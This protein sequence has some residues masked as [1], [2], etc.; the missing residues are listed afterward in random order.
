M[1]EHE[2]KSLLIL[3]DKYRTTRETLDQIKA[4]I[5]E[6]IPDKKIEHQ[7][8]VELESLGH[9]LRNEKVLLNNT[10]GDNDVLKTEID[11][12]RRE[13]NFAKASIK[14]M[15]ETIDKLKGDATDSNREACIFGRQASEIKNQI[16]ALKANHEE[17]KE[18]FEL[19]I[20]KLQEQ[21]KE[22]D[23]KVEFNDKS[24]SQTMQDKKGKGAKQEF[25]NPTEIL[26]IRLNS[27]TQKNV[28][29]KRLLDQFVRNAK[30]IEEAFSTIMEATGINNIEEIVTAFIKAEEQNVQLFNYVGQLGQENDVLEESNRFYDQQIAAFAEAE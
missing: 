3:E 19:D 5:K 1:L 4:K 13:I 11:S 9:Q 27:V 2:R 6:K 26:K 20:K 17:G 22:K 18:E 16:L 14:T 10:I 24:L 15:E 12:M 7:A 29:K 28:E 21:L 8:K 25:Q 30:I 23:Q